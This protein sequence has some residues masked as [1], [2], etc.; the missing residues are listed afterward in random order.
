MSKPVY[1][2]THKGYRIYHRPTIKRRPW[3]CEVPQHPGRHAD[4]RSLTAC[5]NFIDRGVRN[6]E[7]FIP[8]SDNP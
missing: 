1:H 7:R 2:S 3:R 6:L 8:K 5:R 4:K